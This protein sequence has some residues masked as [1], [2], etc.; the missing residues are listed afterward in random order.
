MYILH[1]RPPD[2]VLMHIDNKITECFFCSLWGAKE[3]LRILDCFGLQSEQKK[4]SSGRKGS[5]LI[6]GGKILMVIKGFYH[7]PHVRGV[8][9]WPSICLLYL[10]FISVMP[11]LKAG[12]HSLSRNCTFPSWL[13]VREHFDAFCC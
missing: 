8:S 9:M 7:F 1:D 12:S 13:L 6:S 5:L 11:D 3:D 4:G 10:C 2:G